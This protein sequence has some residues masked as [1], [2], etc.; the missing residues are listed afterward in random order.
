MVSL[1]FTNKEFEITWVKL[2]FSS[3]INQLY[4]DWLDHQQTDTHYFIAS[5]RNLR[6]KPT[7]QALYSN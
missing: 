5:F 4:I 3:N 7:I 1:S 6:H 2:I